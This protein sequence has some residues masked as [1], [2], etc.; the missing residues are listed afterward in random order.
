MKP[1]HL[2]LA[3]VAALAAAGA[4]RRGSPAR[5]RTRPVSPERASDL[6]TFYRRGAE[7]TLSNEERQIGDVGDSIGAV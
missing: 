7:Y 3:A 1:T 5:R 6:F 4:A 2:T